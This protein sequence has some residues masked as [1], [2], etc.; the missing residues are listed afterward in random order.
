VRRLRLLVLLV[1]GCG[2]LQFESH[3]TGDAGSAD[4]RRADAAADGVLA[5]TCG[6][7]TSQECDGFE[8]SSVDPKWT[9]DTANGSITIDT[10]RAYRGS[11][12]VHLHIDPTTGSSNPRA[13][14]YG[15]GGL[16][17][18]ITG[19]I[20]FRVWMWI[21]TPLTPT[22]FNQMI[23][24]ANTAGQG[25]SM[26]SRNGV[27]A[28]NNYT[29]TT[30]AESATALPFDRWTC[31]QFEMPSNTTGDIRMFVDGTELT[32]A[33]LTKTTA[34]PAPSHVFMGLEWVGSPTGYPAADAWMDE[35][36]IDTS[37]TTC[38]Q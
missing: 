1:A 4:A 23:N 28:N 24:A 21:A 26:G 7:F 9:L 33:T 29:D 15:V 20:Y 13:T 19:R 38:A 27:L 30:Y 6:T 31:L 2:R 5:T 34:Q 12:S 37:P 35:M 8:G 14:L 3:G 17:P 32:D 11:S 25:I 36:V 16:Q 22:I 18:A 10:T